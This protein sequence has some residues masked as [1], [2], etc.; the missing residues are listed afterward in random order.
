MTADDDAMQGDVGPPSGVGGQRVRV[1]AAC[2]R[3]HG[4]YARRA[5]ARY[6]TVHK[7]RRPQTI[8]SSLPPVTRG[9]S[10]AACTEPP[11]SARQRLIIRDAAFL[12]GLR[13]DNLKFVYFARGVRARSRSWRTV[14]GI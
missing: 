14:G 1:F 3:Q 2:A 7:Q 11:A 8:A 6:S 5:S 13:L 4:P 9:A 12:T 10:R